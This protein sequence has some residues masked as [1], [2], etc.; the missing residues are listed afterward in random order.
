LQGEILSK[1]YNGNKISSQ[2]TRAHELFSKTL[3][4]DYE[5]EMW[6]SNLQPAAALLPVEFVEGMDPENWI[7]TKLQTVL[8]L[9]FLSV[10]T[11]LF[12]KAVE[13]ALDSIA[14]SGDVLKPVECSLPLGK[15]IIQGCTDCCTQTIAIICKLETKTH[16]LPAWWYSVYYG[17]SDEDG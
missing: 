13:Q 8:T 16:L 2:Q 17:E 1:V 4:L 14:K 11:L 10:R 15:L 6:K 12:R 7:Y 5:L 9:R 3:E